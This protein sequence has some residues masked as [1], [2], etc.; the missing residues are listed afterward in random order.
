MT[1][2]AQRQAAPAA[3]A[4]ALFATLVAG[5]VLSQF[6]RNSIGVLAPDIAAE[7]H[8]A[9]SEIGVLSSAFFFAF[10]AVQLP[11]GVAIDRFGPKRCM[12]VCAA[13]VIASALTFA[14]GRTPAELVAARI[15]MGVG[16]S[17]FLIAPLALY[18]Q[19][20][21]P[22]RFAML[23]GLHIG[24]GTLGTLL[25]T[26][27]LAFAAAEVGWRTSFV[28]AAAVM[29]VVSLPL[30]LVVREP[31]RI[32]P[33]RRETLRESVLGIRAAMRIPSVGRLFVMQ[34]ATYSSF[35]IFVGLWG[36]P[37]LTHVYGYGLTE[38]GGLLLVPALAQILGLMLFGWSDRVLGS[39]RV[40]VAIGA[41][42]T[43]GF[44]VLLALAG[45]LSRTPLLVWLV[46]FGAFAGFTPVVI[47]H[48]KSLFPRRLVGRGMT[49]LNMGSMG[50]VFVTQTVSGLAIDLFAPANGV[51]PLDAY[52]LVF[53]LQAVFLAAATALYLTAR[54]PWRDQ[55]GFDNG[56]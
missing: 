34:M 54:D 47:A 42:T 30:A 7:M 43:A 20:F 27:P 4:I 35:V 23:A 17:C 19:R 25:A 8:I 22:D 40:P 45:P 6:L 28:A 39:H 10:A 16:T 9:A 2:T 26:A 12:L 55:R 14:A 37:Y 46:G 52:R 56:P 18:A 5:Y 50:G 29:G 13:V 31:P 33:V 36:G 53:A 41:F 21:A 32:V 24:I 38:R 51:Y 49:L 15:V 48:G 11:L 44:F 1:V 3:G